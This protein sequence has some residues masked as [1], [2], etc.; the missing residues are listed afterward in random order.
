VFP[1]FASWVNL[2]GGGRSDPGS[3]HGKVRPYVPIYQPALRL[4]FFPPPIGDRRRI[5]SDHD[6]LLYCGESFIGHRQSDSH[7]AAAWHLPY[8][9]LTLGGGSIER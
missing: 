3:I 8:P 6:K 2:A 9:L 5:W 4:K 7:G 1:V